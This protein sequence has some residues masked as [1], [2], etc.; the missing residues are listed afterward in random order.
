MAN[1]AQASDVEAA[2]VRNL[3][4]AELVFVERLLGQASAVVRR[5]CHQ[6]IDRVVGDVVTVEGDG[7]DFLLLP[8]LPI[9]SVASVVINGVTVAASSYDVID[10]GLRV[11]GTYL[12]SERRFDW[13]P[14]GWWPFLPIVV[15]YTHGFDV[16][17]YADVVGVVADLVAGRVRTG[18]SNPGGV[19]SESIG[20]YAVG[21]G[22][23]PPA[24]EMRLTVDQKRTLG[25]F[26]RTLASVPV[27]R[28]FDLPIIS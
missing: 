9:V 23:T 28:A 5:W 15:T 12:P 19:V 27:R 24:M 6:Q 1:L 10:G 13:G 2:L 7:T 11:A 8:E 18:T 22:H 25:P 20:S 3:T 17:V 14:G 16:G 26:R 4:A 21:F